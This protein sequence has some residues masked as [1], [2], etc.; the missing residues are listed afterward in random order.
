MPRTSALENVE[1]PLLYN[2]G[3]SS[4]ERKEKA[5]KA[6]EAVS[7]QKEWIISQTNYPRSAT[8]CSHRESFSGMNQ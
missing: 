8:A 2:S 7:L 5:V 3:I 6:L 1:L 4:K